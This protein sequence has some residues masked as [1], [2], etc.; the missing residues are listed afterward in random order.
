MDQYGNI[1]HRVQP[2]AFPRKLCLNDKRSLWRWPDR[3]PSLLHSPVGGDEGRERS[4][5]GRILAGCELRVGHLDEVSGARL[6]TA[7]P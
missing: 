1:G 3:H 6:P 4:L 2:P 5:E 7:A